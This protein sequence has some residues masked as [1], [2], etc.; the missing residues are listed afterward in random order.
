M[1]AYAYIVTN[2]FGRILYQ[3]PSFLDVAPLRNPK[4]L[5]VAESLQLIIWYVVRSTYLQESHGRH[6]F[7][8]GWTIK[9]SRLRRASLFNFNDWQQVSRVLGTS[10][11]SMSTAAAY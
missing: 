6:Q 1:R 10:T 8:P 5:Q 7:R 2:P 9:R 3:H 4:A 11:S